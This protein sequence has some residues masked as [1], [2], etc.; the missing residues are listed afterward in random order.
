METLREVIHTLFEVREAHE[1]PAALMKVVTDPDLLAD[2]CTKYKEKFPDLG[3]DV[4]R[5]YFQ[6]NQADR[7]N[8]M[9]DYTPEGVCKIV[10]G[11]TGHADRIADLCAGTGSLTLEAWR[12][13]PSAEFACYEISSASLPF[14][15]FNL[16]VRQIRATV[17]HGDLL[18]DT[19]EAIY[20]VQ[21]GRVLKTDEL[22][23]LGF[24]AVI[25]NPPYSLKWDG[26]NDWRIS[27]YP[28]APKSKADYTFLLIG[29]SMLKEGGKLT[30]IL[31]HGVLFR[32]AAEE[33]I[34]V[35]LIQEGK[36]N[37][38]IGLAPMLFSNTTIPVCLMVL[39]N[40]DRQPDPVLVI[41]AA[42]VCKR[43]PKQNVL[44]PE[45][46][47][48]IL[49]VYRLRENVEKLAHLASLDE[50]KENSCNLN[51]PRYVDT[52]EVVEY[53]PPIELCRELIRMKAQQKTEG[54]QLLETMR[55]LVCTG[56]A[57]EHMRSFLPV[58]E[59][60][61]NA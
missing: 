53:E 23:E 61:L 2:K 4:L 26:V 45:H 9:Q 30:A 59:E 28:A 57:D 51:I 15:L 18:T 50:L 60:Y 20:R 41:D 7:S 47:E 16:A 42:E 12:A 10:A 24:D 46:V 54:L 52:A 55:T 3:R 39:D 40:V 1:L 25:T 19:H 49:S 32:G 34:R 27:R 21:D 56:K 5:D 17:V 14:L 36:L 6:E 33:K 43:R 13:N 8:L 38:I 58:F 44:L 22:P 31:P 35:Q 29:L 11:I 48:K 37:S